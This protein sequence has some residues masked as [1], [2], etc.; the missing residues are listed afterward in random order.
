MSLPV[1]VI[2]KT[3]QGTCILVLGSRASHEAATRAGVEYP[4]A[5]VLARKLG[6]K[7]PRRLMGST[8]R[9]V[10]P[11]VEQGA[12]QF[13]AQN[14]RNSLIRELSR[15][16][17]ANGVAPT[18]A[19]DLILRHFPLVITTCWDDLLERA[20]AK[21]GKQVE[22]VPRNGHFT[23]TGGDSTLLLK[24]RGGFD[25]PR[26]LVVTAND[27]KLPMS[28]AFLK[29]V[30]TLLRRRTMFFVGFRPDEEEFE[31]VWEDLTTAYGGELPRGHMAVVQGRMDDFLWQKWIWRG[32]T[33][34]TADPEDCLRELD[35]NLRD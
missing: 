21:T 1:E 29:A 18:G 6:W 4:V 27:F 26:S 12:Q 33:L 10:A 8:S 19:H 25:Q 5:R 17:G 28:P 7:P 23:E 9:A 24:M 22:V 13:Q 31:R 16:V 14:G 35:A 20:A 11:S 2:E 32:L 3:R 34:F 15:L 30:A